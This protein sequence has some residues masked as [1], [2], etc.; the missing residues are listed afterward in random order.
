MKQK[1]I[2]TKDYLLEH[3]VKQRKPAQQIAKELNISSKTVVLRYLKKYKI[4]PNSRFGKAKKNTIKYGEIHRSYLYLLKNRAHRKNLT[5]NLNGDYLW[6]LF[7][8][9]DKKCSLSGIEL[10]FPE[11]W[12]SKSKTH[13]TASLDRIDSSKGYVVDNVQWVHKTINTMKMDMSDKQFISL[14]KMVANNK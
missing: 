5:F 11:A 12:G 14:C 8:K 13:I 10:N 2:I 4:K 7:L 3:Y 6:K 9:Q 1:H